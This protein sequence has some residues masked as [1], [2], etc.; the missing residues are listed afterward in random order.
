MTQPRLI[1]N[2]PPLHFFG[3]LIDSREKISESIKLIEEKL[4]ILNEMIKNSV[5]KLDDERERKVAKCEICNSVFRRYCDLELH[6]ETNHIE[7]NNF[8]CD[9]CGKR[10]FLKWRL[11]KHKIMHTSKP[12]RTCRYFSSNVLCPFEKYGCK[13]RHNN[14][15]QNNGSMNSVREFFG[16]FKT[17]TPEKKG[18]N[19]YTCAKSKCSVLQQCTHCF[20]KQL[21][22]D[23]EIDLDDGSSVNFSFV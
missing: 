1:T 7:S 5:T 6:I 2:L 17:S 20:V 10:F 15:P 21:Y 19:I 16:S 23:G 18:K 13:F 8:E 3:S 11:E 22:M 9:E 4:E 14:P 12:V